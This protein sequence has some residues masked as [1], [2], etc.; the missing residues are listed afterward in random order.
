MEFL[1]GL[2]VSNIPNYIKLIATVNPYGI[3]MIIFSD[4]FAE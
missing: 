1:N 2:R 4:R 3:R